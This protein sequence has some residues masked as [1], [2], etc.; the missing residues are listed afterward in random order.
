MPRGWFGPFGNFV[1]RQFPAGNRGQFGQAVCPCG[2]G[3]LAGSAIGGVSG[4]PMAQRL[5]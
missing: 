5:Q 2:E 4:G 1:V 3:S